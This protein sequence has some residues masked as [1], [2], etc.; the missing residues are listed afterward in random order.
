[1]RQEGQKGSDK[2]QMMDSWVRGQWHAERKLEKD[3]L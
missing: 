3:P 2:G 1:M